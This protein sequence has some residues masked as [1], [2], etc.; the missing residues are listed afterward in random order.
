MKEARLHE[1]RRVR[2]A[3]APPQ[4]VNLRL[5]AWPT[6][7]RLGLQANWIMGG[8]PHIRMRVS[9]LGGGRWSLTM[10]SLM[11]PWLYSQPATHT[12][13]HACHT[14]VQ[15]NPDRLKQSQIKMVNSTDER[16]TC[17][18]AALLNINIELYF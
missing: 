14:H 16:L 5:G 3:A 12:H 11:K 17:P 4:K 10:S 13:T 18:F 8:G 15:K 1:C 9:S 2:A 6:L 7:S